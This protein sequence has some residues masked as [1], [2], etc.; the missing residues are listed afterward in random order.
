LLS[1]HDGFAVEEPNPRVV[2][3]H[4]PLLETIRSAGKSKNGEHE[5]DA[6]IWHTNPRQTPEFHGSIKNL[7]KSVLS[8]FF[9]QVAVFS[10]QFPHLTASKQLRLAFLI[11]HLPWLKRA[12]PPRNGHFKVTLVVT[13]P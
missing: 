6:A 1:G 10:I 8:I 12:K 11:P 2:T 5:E 13:C 4:D 3:G 9:P 7:S